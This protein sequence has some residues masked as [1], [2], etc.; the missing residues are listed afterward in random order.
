MDAAQRLCPVLH[1]MA[2]V[3]LHNVYMCGACSINLVKHCL[4]YNTSQETV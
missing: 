2:I 1:S 3:T 4:I